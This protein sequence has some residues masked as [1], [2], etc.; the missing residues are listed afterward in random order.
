MNCV[1]KVVHRKSIRQRKG[2]VR[3]EMGES[4]LVEL[5]PDKIVKGMED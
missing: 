1:R 2:G 3:E 4:G 5:G